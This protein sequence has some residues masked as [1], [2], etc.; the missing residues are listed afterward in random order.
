MR[1]RT[2]IG[3]VLGAVTIL[4]MGVFGYYNQFLGGSHDSGGQSPAVSL[5]SIGKIALPSSSN[6]LM[7][8]SDDKQVFAYI[9][10]SNVLRTEDLILHTQLLHLQLDFHPV[11]LAWIGDQSL[12]IGT[13][14]INGGIKAL[15]L[16]TIDAQSGQARLI[17]EF[18]GLTPDSTFRQIAYSKYTN[19]VYVL[20][21]NHVS[22][23][24]YHFD[25]NGN[26]NAVD[27]GGRFLSN[28]GLSQ[29]GDVLFFQDFAE[30]TPNLL[31][32]DSSGNIQL[33]ERNG[34]LLRVIRNT[35]YFGHLNTQ[36]DVVTVQSYGGGKLRTVATLS[37]P[38]TPDD[39]YVDSSGRVYLLSPSG[40][41]DGKGN[42]IISVSTEG[43]ISTVGNAF[44][45]LSSGSLKAG[46]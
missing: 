33:I 18:D 4:E 24:L 5:I 45:M 10:A 6:P 29:T 36:G 34:I 23:V 25:T 26:M 7:T 38:T 39:V 16:S 22:S 27:V 28:I 40:I 32:E 19:D 41:L 30:G 3:L 37:V 46:V 15:R 35:L 11:Y 8:I 2:K 44:F 43:T 20:I 1:K 42:K 12:F 17:H 31:K 9:D 21:G 13:E 14:Y